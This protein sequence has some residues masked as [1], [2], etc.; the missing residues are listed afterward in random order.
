LARVMTATQQGEIA[1]FDQWWRSWFGGQLPPAAPED[2][3]AMPGMLSP[4][5]IESLRRTGPGAFDPL[6]VR[7]M[8][9]HHTGAIAMADEAIREAG[10][11]RLKLMSHAIRHEQSGEIELMHGARGLPAVKAAVA[12]LVAPLGGGRADRGAHPAAGH[13]P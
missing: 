3:A 2:H 4:N 11:P 8:S 5:E 1:V 6:F 7:L 12:S 13:R 9:I 10:D